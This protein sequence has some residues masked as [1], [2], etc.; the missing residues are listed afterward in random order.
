MVICVLWTECALNL[1]F[2][3]QILNNQSEL[4]NI[5]RMKIYLKTEPF[6]FLEYFFTI[7][8]SFHFRKRINGV[9]INLK[10]YSTLS[11]M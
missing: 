6:T 4:L 11:E 5:I 8:F 3:Y 7:S 1:Y 9:D 10:K 2:Y